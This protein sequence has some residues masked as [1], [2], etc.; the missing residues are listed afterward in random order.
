MTLGKN[1]IVIPAFN[2]AET[3][4]NVVES[5]RAFGI[6]LVVS[7]GSTD[8]TA[9]IA[10][11]AGAEV[12]VQTTNLGYEAALN[13][14]FAKAM[15]LGASTII[16]F[17]GDG[18]LDPEVL[19]KILLIIKSTNISFIIGIRPKFARFTEYIFN[20]YTH[21]RHGVD[22]ILCGVKAYPAEVYLELGYFDSGS[23]VG[24]ELALF[25]LQRGRLFKT[26][27]VKVNLRRNGKSRFGSGWRANLRILNALFIAMRNDI[28]VMLKIKEK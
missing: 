22:D 3:I 13:A 16:T 27:P 1:I 17:D 2:E 9:S 25:A 12:I 8:G 11:A 24:T 18:Q 23:S 21:Y 15:K 7:D 4:K 20:L 26:V 19:T 6:P 5:V 10:L 28:L 14:G